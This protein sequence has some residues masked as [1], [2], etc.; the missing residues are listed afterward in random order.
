MIVNQ[1]NDELLN[2][3]NIN[4]LHIK[5]IRTMEVET[6]HILSG[7]SPHVLSDL[8]SIRD[9]SAYNLRY[10]FFCRCRN[11]AQQDTVR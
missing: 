9:C 6:F 7:M 11:Y 8:V 2:K 5:R 10:D 3:A 1:H 4:F